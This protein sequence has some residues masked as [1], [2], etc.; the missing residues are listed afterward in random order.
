MRLHGCVL[1]LR[2]DQV[3]RQPFEAEDDLFAYVSYEKFSL[4]MCKAFYRLHASLTGFSLAPRSAQ[5][6]EIRRPRYGSTRQAKLSA[7]IRWDL[8]ATLRTV[9]GPYAV[10]YIR[11][12]AV[13]WAATHSAGG[14]CSN[15]GRMKLTVSY[16]SHRPQLEL[17]RCDCLAGEGANE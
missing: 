1:Y 6:G 14:P 16:T 13:F 12:D 4:N 7:A 9:E 10:V 8:F 17:P 5:N 3:A 2:G 11:G 15:A